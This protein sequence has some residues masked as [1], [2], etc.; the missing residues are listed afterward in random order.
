MRY[1]YK[2]PRL[3]RER[4]AVLTELLRQPGMVTYLARELGITKAAVAQWYSIP[5][6]HIPAISKILDI[7]QYQLRGEPAPRPKAV[8]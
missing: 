3:G 6:W 1:E 4:D 8:A 2:S 5:D 7:P